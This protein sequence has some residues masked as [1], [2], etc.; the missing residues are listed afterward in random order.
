MI[1][2]KAVLLNVFLMNNWFKTRELNWIAMRNTDSRTVTQ[3]LI[4]FFLSIL[5]IQKSWY[6]RLYSYKV[7]SWLQN[8]VNNRGNI[9]STSTI[10]R[11]HCGYA[12]GVR[13]IPF[14]VASIVFFSTRSL[15]VQ[16]SVT[17][18]ST[19]HFIE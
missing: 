16:N 5:V 1:L 2:W 11:Y 10:S 12:N 19:Q 13:T 17:S 9:C 18:C 8:S 6:Q 15:F 3:G 7:S 14:H 4:V